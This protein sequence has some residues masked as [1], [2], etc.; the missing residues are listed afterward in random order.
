MGEI[1]TIQITEKNGLSRIN[2]FLLGGD[3]MS[4]TT[5]MVTNF[6]TGCVA[7]AA[8]VIAIATLATIVWVLF[9]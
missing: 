4:S 2:I 6:C 7:A 9:L 5:H 1:F 3:K 8:A